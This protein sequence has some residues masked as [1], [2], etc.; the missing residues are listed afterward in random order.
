ME[1]LFQLTAASREITAVMFPA[2]EAVLLHRETLKIQ[3]WRMQGRDTT[4]SPQ[5]L[6]LR[7]LPV[8]PAPEQELMRS[9]A[10]VLVQVL[11][12]QAA[13]PM[14]LHLQEVSQSVL[15]LH[16]LLRTAD[17]RSENSVQTA[18]N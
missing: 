6:L 8:L 4:L 11:S 10:P 3:M 9:R 15:S 1:L 12:I 18:Q 16:S 14:N 13:V 7:F 5:E 2:E 17:L